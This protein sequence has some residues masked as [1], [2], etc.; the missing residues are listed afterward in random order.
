MSSYQDLGR[1][2]KTYLESVTEESVLKG[3][4][5]KMWARLREHNKTQGL[6]TFIHFYHI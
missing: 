3:L 6:G 5:T 2:Q 1:K 4:F